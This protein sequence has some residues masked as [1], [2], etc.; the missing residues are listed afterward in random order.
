MA[1]TLKSGVDYQ[2]SV[3]GPQGLLAR[4]EKTGEGSGKRFSGKRKSAETVAKTVLSK[5]N[6]QQLENSML[7]SLHRYNIDLKC[8][9][10]HPPFSALVR[11][12]SS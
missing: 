6:A 2:A 12:I 7:D 9:L 10:N 11:V 5:R 3:L 1:I 8:E 4:R